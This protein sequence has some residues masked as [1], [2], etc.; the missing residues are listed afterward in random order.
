MQ[1]IRGQARF[2]RAIITD[3]G[4]TQYIYLIPKLLKKIL[5]FELSTMD[6]T[7]NHDT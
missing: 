5:K 2:R 4:K 7:L 3:D 1:R 6:Q